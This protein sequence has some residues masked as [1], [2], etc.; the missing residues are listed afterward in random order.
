MHSQTKDDSVVVFA[1]AA[2]AANLVL[3]RRVFCSENLQKEKPV[4]LILP[5]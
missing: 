3:Q 5:L 4:G 2:Q 1:S